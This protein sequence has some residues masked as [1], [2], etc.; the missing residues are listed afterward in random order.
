MNT[1][2]HK[3]PEE[4]LRKFFDD[5]LS[6]EEEK[7]ALYLIAEDHELRSMLKFE[8]FLGESLSTAEPDIQSFSV[9]DN[10]SD[11]VMSQ[12]H[13]MERESVTE[14][15]VSYIDLLKQTVS[16][17]FQPRQFSL[18]PAFVYA[19]P[20]VLLAGFLFLMDPLQSSEPVTD[21]TSEMEFIAAD[22]REEKVWIRFVYIDESA[23]QLAVAGNFSDWEPIEMDS[24]VMDGKQ[25]WTGLVPVERGEHHY[26]FVK[27]GEEWVTDPLADMQ[28]DDGFGNKNAVIY[29]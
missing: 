10:F 26:M 1:S 15:S 6:P 29:L 12:I 23:E 3:N 18:Q 5:E 28:R 21:T 24:Q 7:D 19:L 22:D 13:Q 14:E 8:R 11:D 27:N 25:V 2:N 9:P 17:W 4:L 20:V 16:S